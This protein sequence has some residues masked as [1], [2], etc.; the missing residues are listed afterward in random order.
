MEDIK[1]KILH[2][3]ITFVVAFTLGILFDHHILCK[4]P[5]VDTQEVKGEQKQLEIVVES[6]ETM[7][8]APS[9]EPK[10]VS[11]K[12][13]SQEQGCTIYVDVSGAVKKPG[14]YCLEESALVID[15]V[16]KAGGFSKDASIDFIHRKINLAQPLVNNQKLYFPKREELVCELKPLLDEGRSI[17]GTYNKP[18]T[19]LPTTEP[20]IDQN[21]PP[22]SSPDITN[23]TNNQDSECVN[24]NTATKEELTTLNGV[25]EAT[26]EKIIMGRPYTKVEDLLNVSGIGEA[27]LAKFRDMVCI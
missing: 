19:Q 9:Q 3:S 25:G 4:S 12:I 8:Q 11:P 20:Y 22:L 1:R 17:S 27:T 24:I 14:V 6:E 10:V 16:N 13:P 5:S 23:P 21:P 7:P 26:A 15:A 2:Y 18:V